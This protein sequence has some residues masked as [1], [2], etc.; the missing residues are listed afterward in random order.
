M[1]PYGEVGQR[2]SIPQGPAGSLKSGAFFGGLADT[3]L[4]VWAQFWIFNANHMKR[5]LFLTV[6][7][8]IQSGQVFAQS[9][10][11]IN[12]FDFQE[13]TFHSSQCN[14][15]CP[16]I[17]MS[18]KSNGKIALIREIFKKKGIVD[19]VRS[20]AFKGVIDSSELTKLKSILSS[21]NWDTVKF[22]D[23]TCCD[24]P[25]IQILLTYNSKTRVYKSM[26]PPRSVIKV[27]SYLQNL[28][29]SIKLPEYKGAIDFEYAPD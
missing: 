14:G 15:T 7:I 26:D 25:V 4:S 28:A 3:F 9:D 5:V 8:C 18:V 22:P 13:I 29:V 27:I 16:D 23:R 19:T 17:S 20:G 21:V 12:V 10:P 11:S 24:A 1:L 2:K 6:I